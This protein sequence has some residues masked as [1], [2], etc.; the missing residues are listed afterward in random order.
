MKPIDFDRCAWPLGRL[1][2]AVYALADAVGL[3]PRAVEFP[4]APPSIA[5]DAVALDRWIESAAQWLGFESEPV[6]GRY[7][8]LDELLRRAAPALLRLPGSADDE[9]RFV[10]LTGR[11]GS[12]ALLLGP[13]LGTT[14]VPIDAL[15]ARLVRAL[16]APLTAEIE[17][18]L[19]RARV[20]ARQR[21]HAGRALLAQRLAARTID[22]CWLIRLSPAAR[23]L[24]QVRQ[25]RL[26]QRLIALGLTHLALYVLWLV[27]WWM[28]GR[29]A[30]EGRFD[31]GWL[32]AWGLLLMTLVPFRLLETW[33]AGVIAIDAGTLLKQWLLSGALSLEPEEIRHQGAGQLLGRVFESRAVESLAMSGGFLGLVS[34]L[35]LIVA[36]FVLAAGADGRLEVILLIAWI[37][38][39]LTLGWRSFRL[40]T[41]WTGARLD[42]THELVEGMIGHRTRLASEPLGRWHDGEDQ[43][44]EQYLD[45]SREL[46]R[47]EA[48]LTALVPRGWVL[49]GLLGLGPAFV[50]GSG[51]GAGI[52]VGLGGVLLAWRSFH[53]LAQCLSSLSGAA[54]AWREIA[55]IVRAAARSEEPGAPAFSASSSRSAAKEDRRPI[56]EAHDLVFRYR[57]RGAPV[58][59]GASLRVGS[60]DRLLLEGPSGGGKSTFASLLAGLRVPESGLLLCDGLDR[61]TLGGGEWRRRVVTAPQFHENHVFIGTLAFNLLMGR[62]WPPTDEDLADAERLCRELALGPLLSRMPGGMQQMVGETGWQLSHGERSRL[63]IARAL[64]QDSQLVVLDESFAALDPETLE[65]AL[66]CVLARARTVMVIAHP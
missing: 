21:A 41:A 37:A 14:R 53:K 19:E 48:R 1:G 49:L 64:L 3:E 54:V 56:I 61:R 55:P 2:E 33:L 34:V 27:T 63:F 44:V 5:V 42:M 16:E 29:A 20:P 50:A 18:W 8:E 57:E 28:I 51:S 17:G 43:A 15:R 10:L 66:R 59:R 31:R 60:G 35:E 47:A 52:A 39:A 32:V 12:A 7:S 22:G 4:V 58:L 46:D 13:D 45:R 36:A 23:P 25:A 38:L 40:R 30:L 26:P 65:R 11:R 6:S 24:A 62:R 9:P